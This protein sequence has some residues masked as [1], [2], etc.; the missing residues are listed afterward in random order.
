MEV[1]SNVYVSG[2]GCTKTTAGLSKY[3]AVLSILTGAQSGYESLQGIRQAHLF[4]SMSDSADAILLVHLQA[5]MDFIGEHVRRG[6]NVL[7][8]CMHGMSR[9]VCVAAAY[10][11]YSSDG[12]IS[13]TQAF[14]TVDANGDASHFLKE[15]V[16]AFFDQSKVGA[17]IRRLCAFHASVDVDLLKLQCATSIQRIEQSPHTAGMVT[18]ATCTR[19][20]IPKHVVSS[21]GLLHCEIPQVWMIEQ[22]FAAGRNKGRLRCPGCS[23][24]VGVFDLGDG[25]RGVRAMF[26]LSAGVVRIPL[27]KQCINALIRQPQ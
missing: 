25:H 9:S 3:E 19:A 4:I 1:Y 24:R 14:D 27:S 10:M 18:C 6:G 26:R 8:H 15:Q 20:L 12:M 23:R 21:D 17:V 13:T 5:C 7:I 11:V 2:L 22:C 16:D